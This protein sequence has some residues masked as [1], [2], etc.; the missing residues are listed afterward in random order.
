MKKTLILGACLAL[1]TTTLPAADPAIFSRMFTLTNASSGTT[2]RGKLCQGSDGNMYGVTRDNGILDNGAVFMIAPDGTYTPVH[3]FVGTDGANP[4]SGLIRVGDTFY[5]TTEY[6][7]IGSTGGGFS[8]RGTLFKMGTNG[9][10]FSV[11]F[12]FNG[13]NGNDVT[14]PPLYFGDAL[15]ATAAQGGQYNAGVT[16]RMT[17]NG[18]LDWQYSFKGGTNGNVPA[19]GVTDGGDGNLYG[20]TVSGGSHASG[21]AYRMTT[22]GIHALLYDFLGTTDGKDAREPLTKGR[23]GN[24]YG[25]T[26]S[27]TAQN[28]GTI[29]RITTNGSFTT[30]LSFHEDQSSQL[31][32]LTVG[33]DGEFYG[34]A[35]YGGDHGAGLVYRFTMNGQF[36][37]VYSSLG[38]TNRD[39]SLNALATGSDRCLW[40]TTYASNTICRLSSP[41]LSEIVTQHVACDGIQTLIA[42]SVRDLTYQWEVSTNLKIGPWT[43]AGSQFVAS[44]AYSS[45]SVSPTN[46]M[47]FY[48]LRRIGTPTNYVA[49]LE[50]NA[51]N[52]PQPVVTR[53]ACTG[54]AAMASSP[55]SAADLQARREKMMAAAQAM[56][57]EMN[58]LI[59]EA[60]AAAKEFFAARKK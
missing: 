41:L 30:M 26:T 48:R 11:I 52:P 36:T 16:L 56:A 29:F 23:D 14:A 1:F 44:G 57:D 8:G 34:T 5:G 13:T 19:S 42:M 45:I 50:D 6:G 38:G 28:S 4:V 46:S 54:T 37:P 15:Y 3:L 55:M 10:N 51:F 43:N 31:H 9:S 32:S 20:T 53:D 12:Y 40:T 22:N 17:T 47:A 25:V 60:L 35:F 49:A 21:T 2:L 24:V 7:G 18:T 58:R 27:A 33:D 59:Q 39:S